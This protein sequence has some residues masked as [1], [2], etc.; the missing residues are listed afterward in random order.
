[1]PDECDD[2]VISNVTVLNP[3]HSANTDGIDPSDCANVL[4]TKCRFD[5]GDDDIALKAG[6]RV[7]GR[8]FACDN[9]TVTDCTF[10]HGHGMSIGSE[11][12]GGVRNLTVK[13]CTFENTENGIRIKSQRGKG[14][15]VEKIVYE[16]ITMTNVDP[17]ITFTSYYMYS[18][19]KDP[20]QKATPQPDTAQSV[21]GTTPMYRDIR[22]SNLTATCEESAGVITGLPE[23]PIANVVFENVTISSASG[24]KITN[25][26]GI[27]FKNSHIT[28]QNGPPL[29]LKNAEVSGM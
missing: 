1:V 25:A 24:M 14:G 29:I 4:I 7:A 17:A 6:H 19:A 13:H 23:S 20:N 18:S 26:K 27:Q 21:T 11:T 2:M 15:I 22:V 12:S 16:D 10:Q 5:T 8:D 9:I 3:E 28:V